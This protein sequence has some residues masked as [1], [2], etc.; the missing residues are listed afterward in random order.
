MIVNEISGKRSSLDRCGFHIRHRAA[1]VGDGADFDLRSVGEDG[2]G[3]GEFHRF[4]GGGHGEQEI[5]GDGFL[6]LGKDAVGD[7]VCA[8]VTSLPSSISGWAPRRMPLLCR[9]ST[10][11]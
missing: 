5:A 4:I 9:P 8:P 1:E 2:A 11:P 6:G 3:L 7:E 10:Q